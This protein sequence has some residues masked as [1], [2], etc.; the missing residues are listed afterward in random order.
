MDTVIGLLGMVV[1]IVSVVGLASAVTY[2]VVKISP[3]E[4]PEKDDAAPQT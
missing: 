4:K 1:W 3:A 2:V